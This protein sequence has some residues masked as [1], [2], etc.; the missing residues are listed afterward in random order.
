MTKKTLYAL[1]MAALLPMLAHAQADQKLISKA[2]QG[3]AGAMV[4]LGECY[5]SGAG[6][7]V[8]SATALKWFRRAAD[9]G[10]G[11]GW[12]H[13]S[14]YYLRGT[15][16]P[17]DTARAFSIRKEW[18]DKGHPNATAGL[19]ICYEQGYGVAA[20]SA[21]ALELFQTAVKAG[22]SW[23]HF[24]MAA[25][26]LNRDYNL[27]ADD[28]KAV[29]YLKKAYKLGYLDAAG[30]L[31][32]YYLNNADYKNASKWAKE[33]S[34]WNDAVAA[35][36]SATMYFNGLGVDMDEAK[37]QQILCTTIARQHN[38]GHL[39][40]Q[41]GSF[42]MFPDSSALR[43]SARAMRIWQ[44][45]THFD[46]VA[47][48]PCQEALGRYFYAIQEYDKAIQHFRAIAEKAPN[49]GGS[50]EACYF[51]GT[52]HYW[53]MGCE[54]DADQ[55]VRWL[56]RGADTLRN[57]G[58]AMA[59]ASISLDAPIPDLPSA[60]RYL[61]LADHYG[62][63]AAL[64]QLGQLYAANDNNDMA[65]ECFDKAIGH[66]LADGYYYKA[67]LY[68]D[69]QEAKK[70]NKLLEQGDR[71]GS[72]LCA[73]S[74]GIIHEKGMDGYKTNYKKAAHYY[75]RSG[76]PTAHY[77]LG[78]L[79]LQELVGKGTQKDY[80]AGIGHLA[81]A[82]DSGLVDAMF[83]L[84]VC[85]AYG[86]FVDTVDHEK[87]IHYLRH[88]A[89][90]DNP[91]GLYMMALYH[92]H[93]KLASDLIPAD[94][95]EALRL[96]QK[97]AGLGSA[98]AQCRLGD[99]YRAG[100]RVGRDNAKALSLYMEA[101]LQGS[102]EGTYRVGRSHLEGCGT[103]VDTAA[104]IPYLKNAA[105]QGVGDAA[106]QMAEMYNYGRGGVTAHSDTALAYYL[107]AHELG[108]GAASHVIGQALIAEGAPDKAVEFFRIGAQN[109]DTDATLALAL[110]L[111]DGT[112]V[113][114]PDPKTA[115]RLLEQVVADT[116]NADAYSLLGTACL[117]GIGCPRDEALG[118]AYLDTA[119]DLGDAGSAY[120]LGICHLHGY[121][122]H[123]DTAAAISWME[124]AADN[125]IVSA[126]NAL[127]EI[128][129]EQGE[130][131][132][133]VLYFEK[134]VALGSLDSYCRLGLC[135]Q[136]GMGVV[137]NS[138]KAYELY[139]YA[140]EHA[141]NFGRRMVANCYLNGIHVET[142]ASE[143]LR[144][145]ALAADNGDMLAMYYCGLLL[146]EGDSGIVA[147]PKKAREWYKKAAAAGY[148]PAQAALSR[149][150]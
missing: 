17:H 61:R 140:A 29:Q 10:D 16:L 141:S 51:L 72:P 143:A 121:G 1:L 142:D 115:Y 101:S 2:H 39:Q 139:C 102:A 11:D 47:S 95:A 118:K 7:A 48:S 21:K 35:Q 22:S 131:K 123:P 125:E 31:A 59:L 117:M 18:A 96:F 40:A 86:L 122:C 60:A 104:A 80:A 33:G 68:Q 58:C 36:I 32:Q 129:L 67:M 105:A 73:F 97:A 133:A 25:N 4:L 62:A 87:A 145:F 15:L 127:G 69:M 124:K 120:K 103:P 37:A 147:D 78:L 53:G 150:K 42:L 77:R 28:R 108:N 149:M 34:R 85:H 135:Y 26:L 52:M 75:G 76:T 79:Y 112:G 23:A 134:G 20:D 137:L 94:T 81:Q 50:G 64:I 113:D 44:E 130:Y 6:V 111:R 91:D 126:I 19:A 92:E 71:E 27:P 63:H 30:C 109:G 46:P 84:G 128:Y 5:E 55:A 114:A 89:D 116:A 66:G 9:Q 88:L 82:A 110:C 148:E 107:A 13:L 38:L 3:D 74:L 132:N 138:K 136:E 90:N 24:Y 93:D 144:W 106:Y 65:V 8:D 83:D 146:E 56:R 119:A 57:A 98:D 14:R 100:R 70:C 99:L 12:L 43:D 54:A 45:G 49:R 41:A